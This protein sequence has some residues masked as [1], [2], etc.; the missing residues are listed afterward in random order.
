MKKLFASV[1][2]AITALLATIFVLAGCSAYP[3]GQ[4]L[5]AVH[6]SSIK[7]RPEVPPL[8]PISPATRQLQ[9]TLRAEYGAQIA[10]LFPA[11]GRA[12]GMVVPPVRGT[13]VWGLYATHASFTD[14]AAFSS[15]P[16][17][18]ALNE[19]IAAHHDA[20]VAARIREVGLASSPA[21]A[22]SG[23]A[24]TLYVR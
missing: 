15:G 11:T 5:D 16:V 10:T 1:A 6:P 9:E 20:L 23:N 17:G 4:G 12:A 13:Q 21:A 14:P 8:P 24:F 2:A 7:P 22:A 18:L 19:W 3:S